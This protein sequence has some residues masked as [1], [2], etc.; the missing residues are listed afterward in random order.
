MNKEHSVLPSDSSSGSQPLHGLE[1]GNAQA[2]AGVKGQTKNR[3]AKKAA[4][5]P[6]SAPPAISGSALGEIAKK[7]VSKASVPVAAQKNASKERGETRDSLVR[8]DLAL[9]NV[10]QASK[11]SRSMIRVKVDKRPVKVLCLRMPVGTAPTPELPPL[12]PIKVQLPGQPQ[13]AICTASPAQSIA[14]KENTK[15]ERVRR[16]AGKAGNALERKL[17]QMILSHQHPRAAERTPS[18]SRSSCMESAHSRSMSPEA[19]G[20]LSMMEATP[21][22]FTEAPG[23]LSYGYGPQP[24]LMMQGYPP[25]MPAQHHHHHHYPPSM[26]YGQPYPMMQHQPVYMAPNMEYQ[27]IHER[28]RSSLS[29]MPMN[30]MVYYDDMTPAPVA[31]AGPGS[32]YGMSDYAA[33]GYAMPPPDYTNAAMHGSYEAFSPPQ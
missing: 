33:Y 7:D 15:Q 6:S 8:K 5:K 14:A 21:M 4:K 1:T 23:P 3:A 25:A 22:P 10:D 32:Y 20:F 16:K 9:F 18:V 28:K 12:K 24:P 27:A 31:M 11:R 26:S 29:G 2:V 30:G 13:H 17:S 19:A